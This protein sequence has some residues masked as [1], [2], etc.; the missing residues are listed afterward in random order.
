MKTIKIILLA[1]IISVCGAHAQRFTTFSP[2]DELYGHVTIGA[3]PLYPDSETAQTEVELGVEGI[4]RI[5]PTGMWDHWIFR[6]ILYDRKSKTVLFIIQGHSYNDR[7]VKE[8]AQEVAEWII[9]NFKDAY[10]GLIKDPHT[11]GDG[12]FMLYLS[13]GTLFKEMEKAGDV[14]LR[15]MYL[16]PDHMNQVLGETP[17]VIFPEELKKIKPKETI[18][19][20]E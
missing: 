5:C 2:L 4:R 10:E 9:S 11:H 16:K 1:L 8:N 15:I 19:P 17:L 12:D 7:L 6:D 13:I 3:A 18:V 20:T 14:N